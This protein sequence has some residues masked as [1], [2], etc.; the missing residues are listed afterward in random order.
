[1]KKNPIKEFFFRGGGGGGGHSNK[2][3]GQ[4]SQSNN[5]HQFYQYST[6]KILIEEN[7]RFCLIFLD[8]CL[9]YFTLLNKE[10]MNW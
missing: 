7:K 2:R 5:S 4:G 10:K 9:L 6:K 1:M 3:N 8:I